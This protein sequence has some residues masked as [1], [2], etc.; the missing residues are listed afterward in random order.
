MSTPSALCVWAAT[1]M[2]SACASSTVGGDL[3]IRLVAPAPP[4]RPSVEHAAARVDLDAVRSGAGPLT[5]ELAALVGRVGHRGTVRVVR[6][7]E[8]VAVSGGHADGTVH[9]QTGTGDESGLQCTRRG[10]LHLAARQ[11]PQGRDAGSSRAPSV[12]DDVKGPLCGWSDERPREP[13][14]T[15]GRGCVEVHVRVDQPGDDAVLGRT[16]GA[17]DGGDAPVLPGQTRRAHLSFAVPDVEDG[18][19]GRRGHG[20]LPGARRARRDGAGNAD[21]SSR[22]RGT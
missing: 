12:R 10:V 7:R 11:V 16:L 18:G 19:G 21:R 9:E 1:S 4:C 14:G 2:P 20:G 5:H 6:R 13:V 22:Y 17:F 15:G 8:Q 3:R